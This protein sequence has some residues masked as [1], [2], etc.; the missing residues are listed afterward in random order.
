[1]SADPMGVEFD[2]KHGERYRVTFEGVVREAWGLRLSDGHTIAENTIREAATSVERLPDPEPEWQV[3]DVA[4]DGIG[5]RLVRSADGW[6]CVDPQDAEVSWFRDG[7]R[8][9]YRPLTPV[10]VN[11]KSVGGAA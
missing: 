11:G 7:D 9:P 10:Y 1:M 2:P 3:G 6:T 8:G 4:I 5:N